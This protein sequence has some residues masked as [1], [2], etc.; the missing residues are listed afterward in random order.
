MPT[1][2]ET[3]RV[4]AYLIVKRNQ[5]RDYLDVAALSDVAGARHAA[6]VLAH[7]DDYYTD[8]GQGEASFS[9]QLVH[10][11]GNPRPRDATQVGR[12]ADYKGLVPKWRDWSAVV[13]RLQAVAAYMLDADWAVDEEGEG[14]V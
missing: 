10:Q 1:L 13:E 9:G 2:D 7:A 4:K 6:E 5:V 11:L 3:L 12:L 8:P 14:R